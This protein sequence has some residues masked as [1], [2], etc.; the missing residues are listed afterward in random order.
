M[1]AVSQTIAGQASG[2]GDHDGAAAILDEALA[3]APDASRGD[4]LIRLAR[5]R[6]ASGHTKAAR[7]AAAGALAT[8]KPELADEARQILA[9]LDR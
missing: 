2:L 7:E 6:K 5:E 3:I 8:G 4:V 9:E 1:I